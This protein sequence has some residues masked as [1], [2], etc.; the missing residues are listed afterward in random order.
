MEI[1][2]VF[3]L[4]LATVFVVSAQRWKV[5]D[6]C[7][8]N[9]CQ[10]KCEV[11][12]G[13]RYSCTCPEGHQ[14]KN[15]WLTCKV[16][17]YKISLQIRNI[18]PLLSYMAQWQEGN[19]KKQMN[20]PRSRT[21]RREI[22]FESAKK[23]EALEFKVFDMKKNL[24]RMN[25][26]E[27]YRVVPYLGT[28]NVRLQVGQNDDNPCRTSPC[29]QNCENLGGRRYRC[30]CRSGYRMQRD[31]KCEVVRDPCTSK[32]CQHSCYN[33]GGGQYYCTCPSGQTLNADKKTCTVNDPCTNKYCQWKCSRNGDQA[34]CLCPS[35]Y[36]TQGD[37]CVDIDE[38]RQGKRCDTRY[39]KCFNTYGSYKCAPK[40][41]PKKYFKAYG[42]RYCYKDSCASGDTE[43]KNDKVTYHQWL[44]SKVVNNL[45]P[46]YTSY[47]YSVSRP[48]FYHR[49]TFKIIAG[50][51][52]GAFRLTRDTDY[53]VTITNQKKL[54]GPKDYKLSLL[55]SIYKDGALHY[56]LMTNYYIYVSAYSFY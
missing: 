51:E 33:M 5:F 24:I 54:V 42:D 50:N 22:V 45:K 48:N 40:T 6:P 30:T 32:P 15:D 46:G 18:D 49:I 12:G 38:C 27:I 23:P 20:I 55:S 10:H 19:Q 14:L 29:S 37:R 39:F 2:F 9:R 41:C 35:G 13:N 4:I 56:Q 43:C 26:Q 21:V 52:D 47:Y 7:E 31:G 11:L 16:N 25:G 36:K 1:K 44:Y 3:V 28:L 17:T 34:R 53:R 8:N